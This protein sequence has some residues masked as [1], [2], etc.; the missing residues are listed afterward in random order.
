MEE[1]ESDPAVELA[2]LVR[3]EEITISNFKSIRELSIRFPPSR[4]LLAIG[5]NGSGKTALIEAVGLLRDLLAWARREELSVFGRWWGYQN[6]VY[7]HDERQ[8]VGLGLR[9]SLDV[10]GALREISYSKG[11]LKERLETTLKDIHDLR[12][13]KV[14]INYKVY[15]NG[16]RG[17]PRIVEEVVS[18]DGGAAAVDASLSSGAVKVSMNVTGLAR[19]RNLLG[20]LAPG[21]GLEGLSTQPSVSRLVL[22]LRRSE[23][24][25]DSYVRVAKR[26]AKADLLEPLWLSA[27]EIDVGSPTDDSKELVESLLGWPVGGVE[28]SFPSG[29]VG[30]PTGRWGSALASRAAVCMAQAIAK[31][32]LWLAAVG[33]W[34]FVEGS[35]VL[36]GLNLS[37]AKEPVTLA[38]T[39]SLAHDG[40]NLVP[41]L[42]TLSKGEVP[43][44]LKIA[45]AQYLLQGVDD[46]DL[47][48]TVTDDGR[49]YLEVRLSAGGRTVK[50]VP[51]SQPDGLVKTVLIEAAL[52]SKPTMIVIDEFENSLHPSAQQFLMDEVRNS[53]AYAIIT[54]HSP[55]LIDYAKSLDELLMLSYEGGETRAY[56]F[57]DPAEAKRR[58]SRL[59][60]SVSDAVMSGLL[61]GLLASL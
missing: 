33:V 36:Y 49:V 45:L 53:G 54:T 52:L 14:S 27:Q 40:S 37:K 6:V 50:L 34:G 60:L 48:M 13:S 17:S 24:L 38:K 35:V 22:E 28:V 30:A 61:E 46:V 25:L 11:P 23:P 15:V 47:H 26:L 12:I 18:I 57:K 4:V 31:L 41:Y 32:L 20:E 10:A 8:N 59:G 19:G 44:G 5:P 55:T 21:C 42:Y 29:A 16:N 1:H 9:L 51:P 39:T 7:G 43:E 58:L 3:L 2:R 56:R